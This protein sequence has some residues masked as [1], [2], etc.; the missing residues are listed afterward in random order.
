MYRDSWRGY[1]IKDKGSQD[2][3][4][5]AL[6]EFR[7]TLSYGPHPLLMNSTS[8]Y[9]AVPAWATVAFRY[10]HRSIVHIPREPD[11]GEAFCTNHFSMPSLKVSMPGPSR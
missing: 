11:R 3:E 10:T 9:P 7:Q 5:Y 4:N 8:D 2:T 6:C 1:K